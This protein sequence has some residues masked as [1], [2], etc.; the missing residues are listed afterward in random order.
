MSL[1]KINL[2]I[3]DEEEEYVKKLACG[4]RQREGERIEA[5]W[6]SDR[7]S[8]LENQ[9]KADL[10]LLGEEFHE[11]GFIESLAR[12]ERGMKPVLL[13]DECV[14]KEL[15]KYPV[16]LKFQS[17]DQII[18]NIYRVAAEDDGDDMVCPL[19]SKEI[20]G[21]YA[22]WNYEISVLFSKIMSQ[23]IA[24]RKKLLYVSLAE[25]C[26]E[27]QQ[28]E[29]LADL[30][31]FLRMERGNAQARLQSILKKR[32]KVHYLPA[33][34]NPQNM[35]DMSGEDYRR[36]WETL[37]A[38]IDHD[39]LLFEFGAAYEGVYEDMCRCMKI[40]CPYQEAFGNGAKRQMEH[41]ICLYNQ[42]ELEAKVE[43]V[44][45]PYIRRERSGTDSM[46][47]GLVQELLYSEFGDKLRGNRYGE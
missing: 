9:A 38:D 46:N 40:Y 22:P 13:A 15:A 32:G 45:M 5:V 26:F 24:E 34:G 12:E 33:M 47:G 17:I 42:K 44:K 19:A 16:I 30:I 41:I 25:N 10:L 28:E 29:D 20:V 7:E 14:K 37:S 23:I 27:I 43:Y 18:R 8:F 31:S 21:V 6:Y 1:K 11:K 2:I 4:I 3:L 35:W 39:A 36:L